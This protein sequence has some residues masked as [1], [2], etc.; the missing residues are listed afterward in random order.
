MRAAKFCKKV[1]KASWIPAFAG[2]TS[3]FLGLIFR[4]EWD[5]FKSRP[6]TTQSHSP[7]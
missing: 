1:G 4:S 2:M 7:E 3:A 5:F 6:D